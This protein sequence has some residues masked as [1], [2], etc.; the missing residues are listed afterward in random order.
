M[1]PNQKKQE[2]MP[3]PKSESA[4]KPVDPTKI[5]SPMMPSYP[6][7]GE[8]KPSSPA[9]DVNLLIKLREEA[10]MAHERNEKKTM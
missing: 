9:D 2:V 1:V 6:N 5:A 8:K 3:L 4:E 7:S 10:V